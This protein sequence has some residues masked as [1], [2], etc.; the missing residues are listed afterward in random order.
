[1]KRH[2]LGGWKDLFRRKEKESGAMIPRPEEGQRPSKFDAFR[3]PEERE[4]GLIRKA[5]TPPSAPRV[6]KGFEIFAP[7]APSNV[8]A[9]FQA[10]VPKPPSEMIPKEFQAFIPTPEERALAEETHQEKEAR[11]M[12]VW[13]SLFP[14]SQEEEKDIFESFRREREERVP[15][16]Q[17]VEGTWMQD[18]VEEMAERMSRV[19][20]LDRI[21]LE[22]QESRLTYGF[23]DFLEEAAHHG[24]PLT[25]PLF[26]VTQAEFYTDFAEFF[27]FPIQLWESYLQGFPTEEG[28]E[29]HFWEEILRPLIFRFTDA[30][31][32]LKPK[33]IPGWFTIE[34]EGQPHEYWV[35]YVETLPKLNYEGGAR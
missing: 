20:D 19:M 15:S 2:R 9:V 23:K 28:A 1:M 7:G 21:F 30:M 11:E 33:D 14:T 3:T 17:M 16:M 34:Q 27:G 13:K 35:H 5:E 29:V 31:D 18:T 26:P 10:F 25:M 22:I 4:K 8:P 24:R 6:P 32:L 12:A